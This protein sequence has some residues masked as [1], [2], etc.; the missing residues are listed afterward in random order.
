MFCPVKFFLVCV[1]DR[2]GR[3]RGLDSVYT[4]DV[5]V[6]VCLYTLMVWAL[7]EGLPHQ[8]VCGVFDRKR[9]ERKGG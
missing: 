8:V 5:C 9:G 7:A 3:G 2:E 4:Y 1:T 6:C